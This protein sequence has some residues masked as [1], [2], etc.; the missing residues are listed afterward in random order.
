MTDSESKQSIIDEEQLRLLSLGYLISAVISGLF[1]LLGLLYAVLGVIMGSMLSSSV[2][3]NASEAPPV[4]V[5]WIFA[6]FGGLFFL[7]AASL[8]VAKYLTASYLKKHKSRTFCL[9]VAGISC[10]SI[11]YGTLLGISTFV[12]MNRPSVSRLFEPRDP[13]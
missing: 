13:V 5:G 4:F 11:P 8:A 12:V 3:E 9:V 7:I 6:A 2:I 10:L 1:S